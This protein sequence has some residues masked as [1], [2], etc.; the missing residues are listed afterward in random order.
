[1]KW[2]LCRQ[3]QKIRRLFTY[4]PVPA[5][6]AE[7]N[8]FR[9]PNY[10]ATSPKGDAAFDCDGLRRIHLHSMYHDRRAAEI[11]LSSTSHGELLQ[12]LVL[13]FQ[14]ADGKTA[15]RRGVPGPTSSAL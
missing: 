1:M 12:S 8:M 3:D 7:L 10:P 14:V 9:P 2:F 6:L 5:Q 11:L 15:S 4:S 13:P